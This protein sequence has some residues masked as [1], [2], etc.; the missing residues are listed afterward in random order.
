MPTGVY[1]PRWLAC[2]T[3]EGRIRALA[4]TLSRASPNHA[5]AL[6]DDDYRRIFLEA[7]GRFG[8]TL[9]YVQQT[10]DELVRRGMHD[11]RIERLL[12]LSQIDEDPSAPQC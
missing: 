1:D 9:D 12:K 5:G 10:H 8:T 11:A 2:E 6:T 7:R 3:R 4:F